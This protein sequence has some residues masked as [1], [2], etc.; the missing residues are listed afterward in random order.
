MWENKIQAPEKYTLYL[1]KNTDHMFT[2]GIQNKYWSI[3]LF[4][5]AEG[6]V[7]FRT[8]VEWTINQ[9]GVKDRN[10]VLKEENT[11]N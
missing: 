4:G 11:I 10:L 7:L 1:I 2:A 3:S 6:I 9:N 5:G 8:I